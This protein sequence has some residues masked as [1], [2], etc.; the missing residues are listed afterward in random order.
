VL[1]E[2]NVQRVP[3]RSGVTLLPPT[4]SLCVPLRFMDFYTLPR[5]SLNPSVPPAGSLAP[6]GTAAAP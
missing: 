5:D 4:P 2:V 6:R 3:G 1:V